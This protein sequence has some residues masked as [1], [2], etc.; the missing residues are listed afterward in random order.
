MNDEIIVYVFIFEDK[1]RQQD[2]RV[3]IVEDGVERSVK[4]ANVVKI[5]FN[6]DN[7]ADV[8]VYDEDKKSRLIHWGAECRHAAKI[9]PVEAPFDFMEELERTLNK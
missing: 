3:Y 7:T 2:W 5:S 1:N 9:E 6:S 4:K 8:V